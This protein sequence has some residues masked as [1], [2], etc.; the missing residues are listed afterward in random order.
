M[1]MNQYNDRLSTTWIH[2]RV[3]KFPQMNSID[4]LLERRYHENIDRSSR[5][6][7][8]DIASILEKSEE[9]NFFAAVSDC[10]STMAYGNSNHD[11]GGGDMRLYSLDFQIL[12]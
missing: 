5:I 7:A 10:L 4:R 6:K 12:E 9:K 11:P 2:Q 8:F 3:D 1:M